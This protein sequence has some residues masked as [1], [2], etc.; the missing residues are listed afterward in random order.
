M[1]LR[2]KKLVTAAVTAAAY[3]AL[4]ILLAPI[5]YGSIQFRVSEVLCILP[6]FLPC[7]AWGLFVGCVISNLFSAAGLLD[8]IFG[9]MASLL[10]GLCTARL[11][12]G[13]KISPDTS[14]SLWRCA[15]ACAMPV[16]FNAPIVGAVLSWTLM[17]TEAFWEGLFLF[18]AQVGAGEAA[19][20]FILALPVMR[21]LMKNA[22]VCKFLSRL[23]N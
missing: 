14:I 8:V 10:A 9:S 11:G 5:S 12:M 20:M 22:A 18:G 23:S 6:F 19:V 7:T 21:G 17:P 15:A 1:D 13:N 4:T 2:L 3:A 16:V